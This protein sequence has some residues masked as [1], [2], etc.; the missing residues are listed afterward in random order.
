[1][2]AYTI[3]GARAASGAPIELFVHDGLLV[4]EP[5]PGAELVEA[6]GLVALPGL[7][8]PHTHLREPGFEAFQKVVSGDAPGT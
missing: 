4:G 1:M 6:D 3:R 2:T 8:D 7:V 5:V